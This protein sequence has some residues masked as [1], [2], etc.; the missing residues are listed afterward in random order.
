MNEKTRICEGCGQPTE[1]AMG[2]FGV[3]GLILCLLCEEQIFAV[4]NLR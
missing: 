1:G 2:N 3:P 4:G